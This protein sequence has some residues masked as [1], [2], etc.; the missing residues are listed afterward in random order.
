MTASG[1]ATIIWMSTWGHLQNTKMSVV[2]S[3][4]L[5]V[6]QSA[7]APLHPAVL[8]AVLQQ[9]LPYIL[10]CCS[11]PEWVPCRGMFTIAQGKAKSSLSSEGKLAYPLN[12]KPICMAYFVL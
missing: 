4:S 5:S 2:F 3:N 6:S 11:S 12:C 7:P 10:L 9:P 8:L 1:G